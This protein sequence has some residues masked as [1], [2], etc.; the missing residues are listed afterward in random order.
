MPDAMPRDTRSPLSASHLTRQ[1]QVG[2][3]EVRRL[4]MSEKQGWEGADCQVS[5]LTMETAVRAS[6][7]FSFAI[8]PPPPL[9]LLPSCN[10][11]AMHLHDTIS[12]CGRW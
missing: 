10:V 7:V 8:S 12:F 5:S 4:Y 9:F 6:A 2:G 1:S 3:K 11:T